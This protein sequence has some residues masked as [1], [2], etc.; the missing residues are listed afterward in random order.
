[1]AGRLAIR[2]NHEDIFTVLDR[3]GGTRSGGLCGPA[4]CRAV[5]DDRRRDYAPLLPGQPRGGDLLRCARKRYPKSTPNLKP[6]SNSTPKT[7][8]QS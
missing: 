2:G 6:N 3:D 5:R 4:A 7:I 8:P 1:M